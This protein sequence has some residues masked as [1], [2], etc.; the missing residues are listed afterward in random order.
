MGKG[1]EGM[2]ILFKYL[3]LCECSSG[4]HF[5]ICSIYCDKIEPDQSAAKTPYDSCV[6]ANN[7]KGYLG[8]QQEQE[9]KKQTVRQLSKR[10]VHSS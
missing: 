6:E 8:K 5:R 10:N 2:I 7:T 4:R 9:R 1:T 3:L